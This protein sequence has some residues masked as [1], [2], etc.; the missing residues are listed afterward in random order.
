MN[1]NI[2][3]WTDWS[4]NNYSSKLYRVIIFKNRLF[5]KEKGELLGSKYSEE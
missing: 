5:K 3:N 2:N 1:L 4:I